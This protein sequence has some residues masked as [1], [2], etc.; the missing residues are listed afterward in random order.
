MYEQLQQRLIL[1]KMDE[2][3][4]CL[5]ADQLDIFDSPFYSDQESCDNYKFFS[6]LNVIRT[7]FGRTKHWAHQ[8]GFTLIESLTGSIF[9][10]TFIGIFTCFGIA[11]ITGVRKSLICKRFLTCPQCL[12]YISMASGSSTLLPSQI[13]M[14][15]FWDDILHR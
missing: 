6:Q 5:T 12:W 3:K 14:F 11:I 13:F 1:L 4:S 15:N 7:L 8:R 10:N 2:K 9:W